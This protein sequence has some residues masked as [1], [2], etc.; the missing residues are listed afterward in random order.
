MLCQRIGTGTH[1]TFHNAA[2]S[3][4]P[5]VFGCLSMLG[6]DAVVHAA[7]GFEPI[8]PAM[9]DRI[10]TLTG[11]D[12]TIDQVL[13][14]A[15][16]GAK[17]ALSPEARRHEQDAYGLLLEGA[18]EGI[19]IYWFNRGV[20]EQREVEIF[21]GDPLAPNNKTKIAQTQLA[22]FRDGPSWGYGPEVMQE[23]IIRA[24]MVV[25][26]NA[27]VY[28]APSPQLT[29]MLLDLLNSQVTPV[30][31][32]RGTVGEGDLAQFYNVAG[33]MVGVGEAYYQG[34]RMPASK[35]LARA[36]LKPLQPFAADDNVLTSSNGY[37]TGE[38]A[39]LVSDSQR[40]LD[41]A[42]LIYAMDLNGMNSSVTPLSLAAQSNRPFKWL[43]WHAARMLDMIKGS[44]LFEADQKRII[45]DPESLRASSIRQASA[46][47][48]WAQLRDD[49]TIQLNS[50]D[51]N[52][53]IRFGLSPSDSWELATPQLLKFYVKGG[54][55]SHGEHGFIVSNANWDPYP[56]ANEI[57]AFT[58]ALANMDVA[59][60]QRIERFSNPFFTGVK[61]DELLTESQA[62]ALVIP[63]YGYVPASL[64]QEVQSAI[65]PIT[66]SGNAILATV[67]DLQSQTRLKVAHAH[68]VL[69]ATV[70]LLGEDLLTASLWM[71]LRAKQDSK[72][73]FG[74]APTAAWA[75]F[76]QLVPFQGVAA[77]PQQPVGMLAAAFLKTHAVDAFYP[78]AGKMPLSPSPDRQNLT[79]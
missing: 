28:D 75:S 22:A 33:T 12:L 2:R 30:V 9:A 15:R 16:H 38:A 68:V 59:V 55:Y 24:M 44:Y 34:T 46:W 13:V 8:T 5:V 19:P 70:D 45:Q 32:S 1:S 21:A 41:W 18:A 74:A 36:K 67:E 56:L 66:P 49:L 64:F 53:A 4:I 43:N 6:F 51:H 11:H 25:R 50:S 31:Q 63:A 52:P 7:V 79:P 76:R 27:M 23:E 26:A 40:A 65:N 17:V 42:D 20:G 37:A 35:A 3:W 14:V 73:A 58:I 47:Q 72:R 78:S 29:Q 71:D 61:A 62:A 69:D 39:L 10:I 54:P 60:A 57:E 77:R 48:T